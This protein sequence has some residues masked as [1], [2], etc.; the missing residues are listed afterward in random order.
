M[1]SARTSSRF[2]LVSFM[3]TRPVD[4]T[5]DWITEKFGGNE[6]VEAANKAS[7]LAGFSNFGRRRG[8][9]R[10]LRGRA[11]AS[12]R[13]QHRRRGGLRL[14]DGQP[15]PAREARST[16]G[17][18]R[19]RRPPTCLH[20]LSKHKAFGRPA[21]RW[22]AEDEIAA[23]GMAL[24][25]AF[26]G[27]LG[28]TT[29]SGPGDHPRGRD[30]VARRVDRTAAA[31]GRHA[32]TA[33]RRPAFGEPRPRAC[34]DPEVYTTLYGHH[35]RGTVPIRRRVHPGASASMPPSRQ[36]SASPWSARP[37]ILLSDGFLANG[38]ER[39]R[40]PVG[41]L[42]TRHPVRRSPP[43][44]TTST[45]RATRWF[46]PSADRRPHSLDPGPSR[47]HRA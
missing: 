17:R 6:L 23:I 21:S 10:P 18:S 19:S 15:R 39:W 30:D 4:P 36:G 14:G 1:P 37:V 11:S 28:V 3:Y 12:C 43:R 46:W 32:A 29:T 2:G 26:A 7:F 20:E 25:A 9:Q 31:P 24:G 33:V 42:P 5:I 38:S 22:Q 8:G 40:P 44:R 45:T 27:H 41:R 16:L 13:R 47:A 35:R 34:P